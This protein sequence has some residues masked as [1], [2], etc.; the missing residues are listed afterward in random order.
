M[1]KKYWEKLPLAAL[2]NAISTNY[3]KTKIYKTQY[4]CKSRL[5][6]D[7]NETI[8]HITSECNKL[9]QEQ[10]KT[11]HDWIENVIYLEMRKEFET[12]ISNK[13]YMHASE[14][15][16]ENK[17]H[18]VIRDFKINGLS[19]LSQMTKHSDSW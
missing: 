19:N 11:K 1:K 6:D 10:Y 17:Q 8:N 9:A 12:D 16:R 2:N 13:L 18:Q 7:T 3:V 5:G 4:N 15:V 14:S